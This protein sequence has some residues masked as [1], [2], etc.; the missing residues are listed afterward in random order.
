MVSGQGFN[1]ALSSELVLKEIFA[2]NSTTCDCTYG[3]SSLGDV[4]DIV[5]GY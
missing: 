4:R 2:Q 5:H 3:V 1:F